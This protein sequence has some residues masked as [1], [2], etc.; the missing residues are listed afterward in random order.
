MA[1]SRPAW[2]TRGRI[3][4][5][6]LHKREAIFLV[7]SNHRGVGSVFYNHRYRYESRREYSPARLSR[8]GVVIIVVVFWHFI[9]IY[10]SFSSTLITKLNHSKNEIRLTKFFT[11]DFHN[12]NKKSIRM[13]LGS[14]QSQTA[15]K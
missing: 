8:G 2:C 9:R 7:Y 11:N 12:F 6:S 1:C 13:L 14:L 5:S 4:K 3:L 10:C 15:S